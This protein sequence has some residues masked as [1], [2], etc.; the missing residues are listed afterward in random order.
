MGRGM[1]FL[2]SGLV[3]ISGI[4]Q[5]ANTNRTEVFYGIAA[6]SKCKTLLRHSLS[7]KHHGE[8][9]MNDIEKKLSEP[10][11]LKPGDIEYYQ[12]NGF[13]KLK[14]VLDQQTLDYFNDEKL[15]VTPKR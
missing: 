11:E 6:S 8:T 9:I 15:R 14:Q 2:V 7:K 13:I 5:L 12:E 4:I 10:Y 3:I 1:L